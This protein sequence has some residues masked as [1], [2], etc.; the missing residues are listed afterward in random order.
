MKYLKKLFCSCKKANNLGDFIK[1]V[2]YRIYVI[3]DRPGSHLDGYHCECRLCGRKVMFRMNLSLSIYAQLYDD[4]KEKFKKVD[5]LTE[6]KL[7]KEECSNKLYKAD[8]IY[9][10]DLEDNEGN[11]LAEG[12]SIVKG[13][14]QLE[15]SWRNTFMP[16]NHRNDNPH[17]NKITIIERT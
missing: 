8:N 9:V 5:L 14:L 16:S 13:K 3:S 17:K 6:H 1:A 15:Q 12:F 2:P 10:T 4:L 7:F 11:C